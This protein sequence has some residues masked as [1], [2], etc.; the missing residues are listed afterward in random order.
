MAREK[1]TSKVPF[2]GEGIK[3]NA[4]LNQLGMRSIGEQLFVSSRIRYYS[5]YCWLFNRF[6]EGIEEAKVSDFQFYYKKAEYLLALI[7]SDKTGIPGSTYAIK[8]KA[9]PQNEYVLDAGVN[10]DWENKK[11]WKNP[12]GVFTQYYL[13]RILMICL[14]YCINQ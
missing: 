2:M 11:Y 3:I 12:G 8:Q 13:L 9:V 14:L 7:N 6:Y 10:G 4:G 1:I 5:F